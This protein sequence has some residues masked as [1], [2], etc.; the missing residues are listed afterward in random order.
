[1][2]AL[3]PA[4][5]CF[6]GDRWG[7]P[8]TTSQKESKT[9]CFCACCDPRLCTGGG[10]GGICGGTHVIVIREEIVFGDVGAECGVAHQVHEAQTQALESRYDAG[11]EAEEGS[12]G[13]PPPQP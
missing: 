5:S 1:M 10:R 11:K 2:A 13:A 3:Q 8:D 12:W 9:W 4:R 7:D 6:L